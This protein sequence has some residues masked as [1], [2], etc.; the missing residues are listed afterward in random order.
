M[1]GHPITAPRQ[2]EACADCA[3][4][5][6]CSLCSHNPRYTMVAARLEQGMID[7]FDA[8][9]LQEI[10]AAIGMPLL[11]RLAQAMTTARRKHPHFAVHHVEAACVVKSEAL[12]WESQA[13]MVIRPDGTINQGRLERSEEESLHL[14]ATL[15]RY[16]NREYGGGKP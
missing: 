3:S 16:L 7:V 15:G 6:A 14:M 9:R 11:V 10:V 5:T 12:E 1:S 4:V 13:M 2:G 8:A